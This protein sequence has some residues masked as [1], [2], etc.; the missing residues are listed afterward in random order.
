MFVELWRA[1]TEYINARITENPA[2]MLRPILK[3]KRKEK[4]VFAPKS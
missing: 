2:V 3:K 4:N 1:K